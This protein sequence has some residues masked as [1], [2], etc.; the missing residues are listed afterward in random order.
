VSAHLQGDPR[1]RQGGEPAGQGGLGGGHTGFF[2]QFA[3]LVQDDQVGV[4]IS[5][6]QPDEKHAILEHGRFLRFCTLECVEIVLILPD[7]AR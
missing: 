5:Q 1:V 2:D 3:I 4:A 6:I 7:E